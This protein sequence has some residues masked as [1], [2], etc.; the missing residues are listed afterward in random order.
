MVISCFVGDTKR[1]R[2]LWLS[3]ASESRRSKSPP[4][5]K[6]SLGAGVAIG[7]PKPPIVAARAGAAAPEAI[8]VATATAIAPSARGMRRQRKG[9][10]I[11][12]EP[13]WQPD[14]QHG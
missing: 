11:T 2:S 10:R 6:G 13:P 7:L 8:T 14:Q 5:L 9:G 4:T 3:P 12:P 1:A